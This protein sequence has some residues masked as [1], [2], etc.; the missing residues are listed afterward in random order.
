M[1][2]NYRSNLRLQVSQ[3][4]TITG[5]YKKLPTALGPDAL[6]IPLMLRVSTALVVAG[7][8]RNVREPIRYFLAPVAPLT[9]LNSRHAHPNQVRMVY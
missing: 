8:G 3:S 2:T 4:Q 7:D 9:A 6:L 5:K 1:L